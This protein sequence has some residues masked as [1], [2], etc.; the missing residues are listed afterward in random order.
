MS[1]SENESQENSFEE[2]SNEENTD[3]DIEECNEIIV[4]YNPTV[5]SQKKMGEIMI[6]MK[7][8]HPVVMW[9]MFLVVMLKL[10]GMDI[11]IG[12]SVGVV[13]LN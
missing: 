13:K 8:S 4:I 7:I 9:K 1:S 6:R 12:V 2:N 11:R 10:K 3:S 5:L